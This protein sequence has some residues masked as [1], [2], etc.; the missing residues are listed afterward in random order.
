[1][2][3][4]PRK[5]KCHDQD[6]GIGRLAGSAVAS[7][8]TPPAPTRR[9]PRASA[10]EVVPRQLAAPA[11]TETAS[12]RWPARSLGSRA[13]RMRGA[14]RVRLAVRR[15]RRSAA[16]AARVSSASRGPASITAEVGALLVHVAERLA[17]EHRGGRVR[18]PIDQP[19]LAEVVV[20]HHHAARRQVIADRANDSSVNM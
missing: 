5:K 2:K 20:E 3:P 1:M 9:A 11:C 18:E 7:V 13:Q 19:L 10:R 16:A 14:R 6:A 4:A 17:P 12:R 15:A 8:A